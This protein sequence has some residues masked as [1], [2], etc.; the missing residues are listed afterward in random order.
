[1]KKRNHNADI[2][3]KNIGT[4]GTNETY[5]KAQLN[6]KKQLDDKNKLIL[7]DVSVYL[8]EGYFAFNN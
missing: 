5:R 4:P 3:N 8:D 6:K 1:M 7:I 2:K